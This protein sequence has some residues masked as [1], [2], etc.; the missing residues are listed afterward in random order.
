[1]RIKALEVD[2]NMLRR[3]PDHCKT[4][5]ISNEAVRRCSWL[6]GHV[7]DHFKIQEMCEKNAVEKCPWSLKYMYDHFKTQEMCNK[8]VGRR[9]WNPRNVPDW[10]VTQQQLKLWHD[11]CNNNRLIKWYEDYQKRKAQKA[12]VKKS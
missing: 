6:L 5:E 12:S 2:P 4:H 1:M 11:H 7:P 8:A 3:V 10:F 9:P